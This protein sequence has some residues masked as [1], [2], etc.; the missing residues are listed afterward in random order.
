MPGPDNLGYHRFL[1]RAWRGL[2]RDV[3]THVAAEGLQPPHHFYISF[4]T[5][6]EGVILSERLRRHYSVAMTIV[7]QHAYWDLT[8][9]PDR[10]SVTLTFSRIPETITVP[11]HALRR[12]EDPSQ[13]LVLVLQAAQA[14]AATMPAPPEAPPVQAATPAEAA[15]EPMVDILA[16]P[17]SGA[18]VLSLDA[19]RKK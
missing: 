11:F 18:V 14:D 9:E 17:Q 15:A 2:V 6:A 5:R 19:F 13:E 12:F 8:V 10:F 1:D 7:L 4:D 16:Q 3:L